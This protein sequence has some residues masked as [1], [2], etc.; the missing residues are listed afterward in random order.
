MAASLPN[1]EVGYYDGDGNSSKSIVLNTSGFGTPQMVIV[2]EAPSS[3]SG[4]A[5]A[6]Y[7]RIQGMS[8]AKGMGDGGSVLCSTCVTSIGTGTFD[9]GTT[10]NASGKRYGYTVVTAASGNFDDNFAVGSYSGNST[11]N[12]DISLGGPDLEP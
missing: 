7:I 4:T 1:I 2:Q 12:R 3:G 8:G 5:G 11:D 10:L 6:S 9:V